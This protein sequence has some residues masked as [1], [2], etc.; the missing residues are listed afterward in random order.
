MTSLVPVWIGHLLFSHLFS[1]VGLA[2]G[3]LFI[4]QLLASR[5]P[6]GSTFAWLLAIVLIPYVGVPLYLV[7]GDRKIKQ[8]A[9][10]KGRLYGG[11]SI[12]VDSRSN[13]E[14]MLCASGAPAARAGNHVTMLYN[15]E[16][17]FA[18]TMDVINAAKHTIEI[19]TLILAGDEV[20]RAV[21][22]RLEARA[23]AG[24]QVRVLID[25]L[26]AF[27]SSGRELSKLRKAG[28]RVAKFM[29]VWHVPFRGH[30]NLRL[31]R[32]AVIADGREAVLGGLNVAREYMGPTPLEGRWRDFSARVVGPAVA[33][34]AGV[35]AADWK[36][37]SG[38]SLPAVSPIDAT[39]SETIQVV[40]SGPDVE[41]DLLYDAFISAVFE[42]RRRLWIAT[43]Y[44]VP[45]EALTRA[46]V[47]AARRGVD[48]RIVVPA[49]SNHVTA[50]F[51][52]ASYLRQIQDVGGR[53]CCFTPGMMHGKA[54]LVD[55]TLGVLGSAN[56]DMRSLFLNYEIALFFSTRPEIDAL[57]TWFESLLPDCGTLAP[58]GR[59][60]AL[61][62]AV[63]RLFGPLA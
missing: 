40:A 48:V 52:G 61:M 15:G 25:A 6:A 54:I 17:A 37:A 49:K 14:R 34:V 38:E 27:R 16:E 63:A 4:G 3:A 1:I 7:I 10:Q 31:H 56:V 35:F 28:G 45:D 22:E 30:A 19:S 62:E 60:R 47:L 8:R 39:G 29:P 26:F 20:G 43:P 32:K 21:L 46:I 57:A 13:I 5:R 51:A 36:F 41:S 12:A 2:L 9:A 23:K 59:S 33:D 42:A 50:D 24:V 44:F 53:I 11:P 58:A 55:D 18:A